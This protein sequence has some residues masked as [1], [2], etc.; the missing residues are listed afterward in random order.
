MGGEK[1]GANEGVVLCVEGSLTNYKGERA[2]IKGN[3]AAPCPQAVVASSSH[4]FKSATQLPLQSMV[5]V[6]CIM[7]HARGWSVVGQGRHK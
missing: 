4:Y 5:R 7:L 6:S 2:I 1:G 3:Y